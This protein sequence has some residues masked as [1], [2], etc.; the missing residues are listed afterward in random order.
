[1]SR[2]ETRIWNLVRKVPGL[3]ESF[4]DRNVDGSYFLTSRLKSSSNL[5]FISVSDIIRHLVCLSQSC[6]RKSLQFTACIG[7]GIGRI[8]ARYAL[9]VSTLDASLEGK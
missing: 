3:E 4:T 1:M 5:S 8:V 6:C 7:M 2:E 9:S